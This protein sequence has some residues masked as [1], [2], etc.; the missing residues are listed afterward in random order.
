MSIPVSQ[1]LMHALIFGCNV[2]LMLCGGFL[3]L[4]GAGAALQLESAGFSLQWLLLL[5]S[6]GSR[7]EGSGVVLHGLI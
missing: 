4:R 2:S 7:R 1:S 6:P 3:Q 5:P